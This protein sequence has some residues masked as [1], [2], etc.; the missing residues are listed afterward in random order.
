LISRFPRHEL[1]EQRVTELDLPCYPHRCGRCADKPAPENTSATTADTT[2]PKIE[3]K[4]VTATRFLSSGS[5]ALRR[6]SHRVQDYR[7]I[8][9]LVVRR[10]NGHFGMRGVRKE[11]QSIIGATEFQFQAIERQLERAFFRFK[12][13]RHR[14]SASSV[15]APGHPAN[16]GKRAAF[17]ESDPAVS[18]QRISIHP[19]S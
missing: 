3:N 1:V 11:D 19:R 18:C 2:A 15:H 10:V 8:E 5:G 7:V 14:N 16:A 6:Q 17:E 13:A 9:N 12:T 4:T